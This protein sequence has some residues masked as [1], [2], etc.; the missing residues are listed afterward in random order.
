MEFNWEWNR[1]GDDGICRHDDYILRVEQMDVSLWWFA[2]Y[3]KGEHPFERSELCKSKYQAIGRAEGIVMGH[4][5]KQT[6]NRS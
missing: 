5:L 6:L 3:Y 4:S 1:E 2:V